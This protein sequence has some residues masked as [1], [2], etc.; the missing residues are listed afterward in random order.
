MTGETA[1]A[2]F[3][4]TLAARGASEHTVRSYRGTVGRYLAWCERHGL[5]WTAIDRLSIRLFLA[6]LREGHA[7]STSAQ[8]IAAVRS[9]YGWAIRRDLLPSSPWSAIRAPKQPRR[10]PR[11]LSREEIDRLIAACGVPGTVGGWREP[12]GVD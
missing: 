11:F 4:A 2:G 12:L 10:L 9:F 8:R 5:D 3:M 1:L 7:A 6:E